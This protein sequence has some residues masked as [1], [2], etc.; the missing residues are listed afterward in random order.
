MDDDHALGALTRDRGAAGTLL[1][2]VLLPVAVV[3]TALVLGLSQLAIARAA[4]Q[5]GADAAALAAGPITFHAY[6]GRGDPVAAA[7]D[8]AEDNGL[9]LVRCECRKDATWAERTVVVGVETGVR[10]LGIY[11]VVVTA[12]AAAR[13]TPVDLLR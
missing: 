4:A 12:E 8:A 5:A 3:G 6:D 13:F 11:P 1:L 2:A 9:T 10:V 7:R